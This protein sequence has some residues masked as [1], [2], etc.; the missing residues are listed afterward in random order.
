MPIGLI[1]VVRTRVYTG[2]EIIYFR[3]VIL[4]EQLV[5]PEFKVKP[6]EWRPSKETVIQVEAVDIDVSIQIATPERA[7]AGS[8]P[9]RAR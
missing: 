5:A 1:R 2:G 8:R 6:F 3:N 7:T 4:W 9:P